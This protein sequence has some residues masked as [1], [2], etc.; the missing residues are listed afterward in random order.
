MVQKK[1]LGKELNPVYSAVSYV[2]QL[3]KGLSRKK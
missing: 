1:N 3:E 2:F